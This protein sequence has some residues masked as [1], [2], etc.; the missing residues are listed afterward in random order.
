MLNDIGIKQIKWMLKQ[1]SDG[2]PVVL[3]CFEDLRKPGEWCHRSMFA[4][5][6]EKQTGKKVVE[7]E[8]ADTKTAKV[9]VDNGKR[10][11]RKVPQLTF[12]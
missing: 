6:Y 9:K 5:W 1:V 2:K 3:L 4:E 11:S 12:F 10:K 8:E 7:L